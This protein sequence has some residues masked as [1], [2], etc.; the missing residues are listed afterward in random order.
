MTSESWFSQQGV[1]GKEVWIFAGHDFQSITWRRVDFWYFAGARRVSMWYLE[2]FCTFLCQTRQRYLA[3]EQVSAVAS[4]AEKFSSQTGFDCGWDI[5]CQEWRDF[6]NSWTG[7]SCGHQGWEVEQSY[8]LPLSIPDPDI[9]Q[10]DQIGRFIG[11]WANFQSL[12]QQLI[13]PN[14]QHSWV[15]F[16][17]VSKSFIFLVKL[18][19]DH[20]L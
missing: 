7:F 19:L 2:I 9:E 4:E 17:K 13:C 8:F 10:W 14:L 20:F 18:V 16:V 1:P 15:I 3:V 11:L 5:L 12:W 6:L